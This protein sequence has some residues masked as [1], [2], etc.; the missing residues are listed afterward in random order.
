M[1]TAAPTTLASTTLTPTTLLTTSAPTTAAPT[2]APTTPPPHNAAN[3]TLFN[4]YANNYA[5][6]LFVNTSIE[7]VAAS[8]S[9][10][11][12]ELELFV[13]TTIEGIVPLSA[14]YTLED[15]ELNVETEITG[16]AVCNE[17]KKNW[18]GWSK[19]G[20]ASFELDLINDAGFRPMSWDGYIYKVLK[21]DK[22]VGIY[23]S[24]GVTLAFPVVSPFPTFGFK[25]VLAIGIKNK[26]AVSGN[27]FVHFFIDVFGCLYKLTAEGLNRLGYEEYLSTLINPVL[28]WDAGQQRLYIS[29]PD[30]G[31]IYNEDTLTGGY[32]NLTGLYRIAND[33]KVVS[34]DTVVANAVEVATD[35]IDFKRRGMKSIESMQFDAIS[36]IDLSAAIDYRYKKSEPFRTTN[37]SPL[38]DE[39]VA[40]I[41]TSGTEFRI[42]LKGHSHGTFDLS[43][44]SVQF[45]YIDQ[46]FT[47]D[48]K[49]E[50]YDY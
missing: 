7:G 34:P 23:G 8:P 21:L 20:E 39:G 9:Y 26:E 33:I 10:G 16:W 29:D 42:R 47:R 14:L 48:P 6:V 35:I 36:D 15:L 31:Y 37:W 28:T 11:L 1:T 41:R 44:I 19:I 45:K 43:Y 40:H 46:R 2:M 17:L 3:D 32:E 49:G 13:E 12:G 27:E 22:N 5:G 25:E 24:G 18:V 38:N 4:C 50:L 30:V